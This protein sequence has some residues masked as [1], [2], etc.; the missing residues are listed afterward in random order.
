MEGGSGERK[1]GRERERD[2]REKRKGDR[3]EKETVARKANYM[4]C[5]VEISH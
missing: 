5:H 3:K 1:G 4:L 2:D